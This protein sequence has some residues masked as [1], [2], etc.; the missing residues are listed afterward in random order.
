ML[1]DRVRISMWSN[2]TSWLGTG[3]LLMA[4]VVRQQVGFL[5]LVEGFVVVPCLEVSTATVGSLEVD[6]DSLV[7]D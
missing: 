7:V 1:H 5:V 3:Y 4:V 2:L 6:L